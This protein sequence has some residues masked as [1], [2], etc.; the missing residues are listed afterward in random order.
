MTLLS[1]M[2]RLPCVV[3]FLCGGA[4]SRRAHLSA[5]PASCVTLGKYVSSPPENLNEPALKP[6][7]I[8]LLRLAL[9]ECTSFERCTSWSVETKTGFILFFLLHYRLITV[10]TFH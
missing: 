8:E 4:L 1:D 9:A 3:L 6:P 5:L 7:F 2:G 10:H